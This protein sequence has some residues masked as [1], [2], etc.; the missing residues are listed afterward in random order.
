MVGAPMDGIPSELSKQLG[1]DPSQ[2]SGRQLGSASIDAS[3]LILTMTQQ[4]R[5]E[6]LHRYPRASRRTFTISEFLRLASLHDPATRPGAVQTESATSL[7][8]LVADVSQH[9][10]KVR[11]GVED[12]VPD[13]YRSPR[14]VHEAVAA[15]I[16]LAT[17]ALASL[18]TGSRP[19]PGI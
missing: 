11:L 5:D 6:L 14:A 4:Q 19:N 18:L 13:P 8:E 12:D 16:D 2:A 15:Q 7:R 1:G 3:D 17:R 10:F 9:R